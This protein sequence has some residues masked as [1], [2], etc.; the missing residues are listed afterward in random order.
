MLCPFCYGQSLD[1]EALIKHVDD[2]HAYQQRSVVRAHIHAVDALR[3]CAVLFH[4]FV[5][6]ACCCQ[7][8]AWAQQYYVFAEVPCLQ[9]ASQGYATASV[10]ASAII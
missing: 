10:D 6:T 4:I 3:L 7:Q 1:L 2:E 9:Q 8:Q 5:S